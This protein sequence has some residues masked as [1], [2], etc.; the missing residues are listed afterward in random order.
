MIFLKLNSK[1][2]KFYSSRQRLMIK[3]AIIAPT[4][5]ANIMNSVKNVSFI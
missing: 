3:K 1:K 4:T 2:I 5:P